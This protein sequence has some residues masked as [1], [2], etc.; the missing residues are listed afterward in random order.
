L[1]LNFNLNH[2]N[3]NI[4]GILNYKVQANCTIETLHFQSLSKLK[5]WLLT[6]I[7]RNVNIQLVVFTLPLE[8]KI[9]DWNCL[10]KM[11]NLPENKLELHFNIYSPKAYLTVFKQCINNQT[12]K[13]SKAWLL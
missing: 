1:L 2:Q 5:Y 12:S 8:T 4:H 11:T 9:N 7:K 13:R 3:M 10:S 6:V